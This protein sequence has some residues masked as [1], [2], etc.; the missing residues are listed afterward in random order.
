MRISDRSNEVDV[1]LYRFF[2]SFRFVVSAF[3]CSDLAA[4]YSSLV[5]Q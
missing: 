4:L 5:D 1:S 3:V 2:Q